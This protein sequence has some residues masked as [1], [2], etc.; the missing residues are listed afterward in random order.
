VPACVLG[1]DA[2]AVAFGRSDTAAGERAATDR[3]TDADPDAEAERQAD[4]DA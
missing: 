1:A 3:A 4:P 2:V